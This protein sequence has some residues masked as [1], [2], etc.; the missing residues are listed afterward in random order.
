MKKPRLIVSY[1]IQSNRVRARFSKFL[2]KHGVRLQYSVFELSHSQR[3]LN[4]I[5]N[6]IEMRFKPHFSSSDSVLIYRV[7][8]LDVISYGSASLLDDDL[9]I[10]G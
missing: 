7:D 9:I 6:E 8:T 3:M 1:D 10:I 2:M 4:L 5:C